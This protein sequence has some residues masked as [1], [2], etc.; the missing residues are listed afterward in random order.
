[1][2]MTAVLVSVLFAKEILKFLKHISLNIYALIFS[3][4]GQ[5]HL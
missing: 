5:I 4:G 3:T 1:M 2:K